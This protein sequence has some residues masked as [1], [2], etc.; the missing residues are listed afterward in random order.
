VAILAEVRL[1]RDGLAANLASRPNLS[2]L[3][4]ARNGDEALA[5]LRAAQPEVVVM[6][7]GI[8]DS[9]EVVR[10]LKRQDPRVRII[11]FGVDESERDIVACAEAGVAGYLAADGSM[12]DLVITIA[13]CTRGELICSPR[14]AATLFHRIGC[15]ASGAAPGEKAVGLTGR[16]QQIVKLID[17]GLSNKEI[18]QRLNIELA[19]V[20]NHV[21]NILEKL[22]V[23]TRAEAAARLRGPAAG[24]RARPAPLADPEPRPI[25]S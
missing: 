1:Y 13:S 5:L 12:D 2:V 16:E 6:D 25:P 8:R 22:K 23:S 4:T 10:A 11:A 24:R 18:A 3:G 15:L 17:A 7:I 21:H 19:T 14:I 20:K 9:L